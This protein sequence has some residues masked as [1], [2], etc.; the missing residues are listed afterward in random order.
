MARALT[1]REMAVLAHVVSDPVAWWE[2]TNAAENI[3]DPE[4]AL[5]AKVAKWESAYDAAAANPGYQTRADRIAAG[6]EE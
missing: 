4:V 2:H 3:T 1:S 5:A 6:L